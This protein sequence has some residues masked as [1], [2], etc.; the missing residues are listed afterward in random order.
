MN[1]YHTHSELRNCF[2]TTAHSHNNSPATRSNT[3]D[4][5]ESFF[6][7][8]PKTCPFKT[9]H[10]PGPQK[11]NKRREKAAEKRT[12]R[13]NHKGINLVQQPFVIRSRSEKRQSDGILPFLPFFLTYVSFPSLSLIFLALTYS[14]LGVSDNKNGSSVRRSLSFT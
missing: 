8:T 14:A 4:Y 7:R 9:R 2:F 13:V 12:P 11:K 5:D 3:S 1:A 10:K 6:Y